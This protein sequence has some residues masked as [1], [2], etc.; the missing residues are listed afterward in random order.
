VRRDFPWRRVPAY[1]VGQV[2]G[3]LGAAAFLRAMFGTVGALGATLPDRGVTSGKALAMEVVLTA[4]LVNTILGTAYGARKVGTNGAIAVRV[5]C[6]GRTLG[7]ADYRFLDESG[8]FPGA[9]CGTRR[10]PHDLDLSRRTCNWALIAVA[11]E[12]ILK[13]KPQRP[14]GSPRRVRSESMIRPGQMLE[15]DEVDTPCSSPVIGLEPH[16]AEVS[17]IAQTGRT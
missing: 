5:H 7:G 2:I 4:G 17:T 12:W 11:F 3:G 10:P 14:A 15:R 6:P 8:P 1:V 16:L 9:G 13:G